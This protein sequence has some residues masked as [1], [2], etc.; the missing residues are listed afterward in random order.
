MKIF[1]PAIRPRS[2]RRHFSRRSHAR[3]HAQPKP[4]GSLRI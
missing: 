1:N 3:V 4:P 2:R